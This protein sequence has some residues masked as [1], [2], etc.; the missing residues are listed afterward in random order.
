M[1]TVL[2]SEWHLTCDYFDRDC[3]NGL[4]PRLFVPDPATAK[5]AINFDPSKAFKD[6]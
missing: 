1:V 5:A 4:V 2:L 3:L 6:I